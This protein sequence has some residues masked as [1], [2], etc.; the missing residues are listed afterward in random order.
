MSIAG[1]ILIVV[2][3]VVILGNPFVG[4]RVYQNYNFGYWPSGLGMI[5]A[6]ILVLWLL[7]GIRLR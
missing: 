5:L 2:L 7:G 6:I 4:P 1:L 3:L